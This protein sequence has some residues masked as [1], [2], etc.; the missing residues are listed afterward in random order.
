MKRTWILAIPLLVALVLLIG[1]GAGACDG[2]NGEEGAPPTSALPQPGEWVASTGAS[3]FTFTFTVSP[4]ST[5]ITDIVYYFEEFRCG[6][7]RW[8]K[9]VIVGQEPIPLHSLPSGAEFTIDTEEQVY[10]GYQEGRYKSIHWY[11]FVQGI[12]DETST[13]ASGTWEISSA[14]ATCQS[15]T[16]EAWR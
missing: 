7:L 12:F 6:G 11:I 2:G 10:Q 8:G 3:E 15:G 13:H 9:G 4:D 5:S 14:A 16:W 1:M